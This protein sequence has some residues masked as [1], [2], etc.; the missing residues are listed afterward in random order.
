[1]L[2]AAGVHPV[3]WDEHLQEM[4]IQF[5]G[6]ACPEPAKARQR[7]V[8]FQVHLPV[9][10]LIVSWREHPKEVILDRLVFCVSFGEAARAPLNGHAICLS[11]HCLVIGQKDAAARPGD[12]EMGTGFSAVPAAPA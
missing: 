10:A 7:W 8:P 2:D 3:R 1:V 5:P 12:Q 9:G 11:A 6:R 4:G